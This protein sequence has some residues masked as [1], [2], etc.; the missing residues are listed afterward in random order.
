MEISKENICECKIYLDAIDIADLQ[1]G[2]QITRTV[3]DLHGKT[4][5]IIY[6]NE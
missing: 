2:K 6:F 3:Q 1:E 4:K 5:Y